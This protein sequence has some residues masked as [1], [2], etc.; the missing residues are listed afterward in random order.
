MAL[1]AP[2]LASEWRLV[3]MMTGLILTA[4][5]AGLVFGSFVLSPLGDSKGRRPAI[6][7]G[8][9]IAAYGTV[10]GAYAAD[11]TTLMLVRFVAGVGLGLAMP[12]VIILAV[13][14]MPRRLSAVVVAIVC[15]GYALGAGIGGLFVGPYVAQDYTL[16]F[17]AGGA[18]TLVAL[19]GSFLWLPESPTILSRTDGGDSARLRRLVTAP[20]KNM[21]G[22]PD[23]LSHG[24]SD[25]RPTAL[26]LVVA[27]FAPEWRLRTPLLW[28]VNF[29][30]MAL[31]YYFVSW[32]PSILSAQGASVA[33]AVSGAAYFSFGGVLGGI[34]MSLLLRPAGPYI[35]LA[36]ANLITFACIAILGLG[37]M[38]DWQ[39]VVVIALSGASIIGSQFALT[40]IVNQIYPGA[41]R[42]TALGYAT[43]AGRVGAMVAPMTG[44]VLLS[45]ASTPQTAIL[46]TMAFAAIALFA[47]L[48]LQKQEAARRTGSGMVHGGQNSDRA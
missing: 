33:V 22:V 44:G 18:A 6:L 46:A 31:V 48:T 5:V 27:L 4:S 38:S 45:L 8:L 39:F 17:K 32:L 36:S 37:T 42:A 19:I 23:T 10:A 13:E 1:A 25:S 30:N 2:S 26:S 9:G 16:V 47:I 40:A 11:I 41:I 3:P 35:I 15:S 24:L 34:A 21:P 20:G 14:V 28:A 43:G 12:V 29:A 7:L